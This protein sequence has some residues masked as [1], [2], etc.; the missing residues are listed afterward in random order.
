MRRRFLWGDALTDP[1]QVQPTIFDSVIGVERATAQQIDSELLHEHFRRL[2]TTMLAPLAPILVLLLAHLGEVPAARLVVWSLLMFGL[3]YG[4]RRNA[5]LHLGRPALADARLYQRQYRIEWAGAVAVSLGWA[6]SLWLLGNGQTDGLLYFRLVFLA[7]VSAFTLS[8]LGLHPWFYGSFLL[9]MLV[10]LMVYMGL[11]LP[12]YL[13]Q[14]LA[15]AALTAV[16]FVSLGARGRAEHHHARGWVEARLNQGLL[17]QRLRDTVTELQETGLRL[18]A[19]SAE[20]ER[21]NALLK[22]VAIHDALTGAYNRGY[23]QEALHTSAAR[24]QRYGNPL[25]VMMVDID[26]FK[27]VNDHHGHAAGDEV[28]RRLAAEAQRCLRDGD[29]FGRWGGEEFIVLLP[30]IELDGAT[31]VAERLRNSIAMLSFGPLAQPFGVTVSIGVSQM[32]P[33]ESVES[34]V[35]RAD[36]AL[37]AAKEGGRNCVVQAGPPAGAARLAA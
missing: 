1:A 11:E 4:R 35:G 19:K 21:T 37:Y 36:A 22:D 30:S 29:V 10:T 25:C 9:T 5:V 28:L 2:S 17:V 16:F 27:L 8:I 26:H 3:L 24:L 32:A 12:G 20:L 13:S 34:L 18:E 14:H 7:G 31:E 15:L 33:G 23:V 6:S